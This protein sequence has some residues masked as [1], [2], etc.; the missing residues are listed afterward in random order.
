MYNHQK[1]ATTILK[2]YVITIITSY[3]EKVLRE[4]AK[5]N[6]RMKFFNI[7]VIGFRGRRYPTIKNIFTSYEF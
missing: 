7:S 4:A 3:H 2:G 1:P 5:N 6:R